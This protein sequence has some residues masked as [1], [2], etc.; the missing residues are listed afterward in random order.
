MMQVQIEFGVARERYL[1][2]R[3]DARLAI[4]RAGPL[5]MIQDISGVWS[6]CPEATGRRAYGEPPPYGWGRPQHTP[7]RDPFATPPYVNLDP[8]FGSSAWANQPMGPPPRPASSRLEASGEELDM[9][10]RLYGVERNPGETDSDFRK[11]VGG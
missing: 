11:R 4:N 6:Y 10:G 2:K 7:N 5:L 1:A 9:L 8:A 3:A